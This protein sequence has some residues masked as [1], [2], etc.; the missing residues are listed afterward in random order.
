MEG[1]MKV[2]MWVAR[3]VARA[4]G[5]PLAHQYQW[6]LDV[7]HASE[8]GRE[9]SGWGVKLAIAAVVA[10]ACVVEASAPSTKGGVASTAANDIEIGIGRSHEAL[11]SFQSAV[12]ALP[13]SLCILAERGHPQC[14]VELLKRC[15]G[16]VEGDGGGRVRRRCCFALRHALSPDMWAELCAN[17]L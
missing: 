14:P 11:L 9:A 16:G 13:E 12:E 4:H 2:M 1:V 5:A 15:L 7:F 17:I 10:V 8:R 6:I 3:G